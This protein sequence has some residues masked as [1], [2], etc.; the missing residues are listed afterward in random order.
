MSKLSYNQ[1]RLLAGVL[2]LAMIF[3]MANYCCDLGF[4]GRVFCAFSK[5]HSG[6]QG[7]EKRR[8]V[9]QSQCGP[10]GANSQLSDSG[11]YIR[12]DS[13]WP[14]DRLPDDSRTLPLSTKTA[15]STTG[16]KAEA[17]RDE[18]YDSE[19]GVFLGYGLRVRLFG[20]FASIQAK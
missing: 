10:D 19:R 1:H 2:L 12:H 15:T 16:A 6:L 4:F 20:H 14:I 7:S 3:A 5:K 9:A 13:A 8:R 17:D 11:G 18:R